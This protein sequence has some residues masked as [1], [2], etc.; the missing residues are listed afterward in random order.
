MVEVADAADMCERM[1]TR[2]TPAE[3]VALSV[4]LGTCVL[5]PVHLRETLL[6]LA[7]RSLSETLWS[8]DIVEELR[9]NLIES[10]TS[11]RLTR[12]ERSGATSGACCPGTAGPRASRGFTRE[13]EPDSRL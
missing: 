4:A 2:S 11:N 10:A 9:R 5:H 1:A 13:Q 3:A 7:E 12:P 8:D 6:R